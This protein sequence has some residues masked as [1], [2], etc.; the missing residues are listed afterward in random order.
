M[1]QPKENISISVPYCI[2]SCNK[3]AGNDAPASGKCSCIS[4]A[5]K[6]GDMPQKETETS[7]FCCVFV[8]T[9]TFWNCFMF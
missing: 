2:V 7:Q 8:Q 9:K 4:G 3:C 5:A 6:I 1:T